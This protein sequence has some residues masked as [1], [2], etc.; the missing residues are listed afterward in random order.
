MVNWS[1]MRWKQFARFDLWTKAEA[2][3]G[4][5]RPVK[6][7]R[8]LCFCLR[9][10]R[11]TVSSNIAPI[12]VVRG[13]CL[14]ASAIINSIRA[15]WE[16]SVASGTT[17]LIFKNT[18]TDVSTST[19]YTQKNTANVHKN[20]THFR[21]NQCNESAQTFFK[22]RGRSPTQFIAI[23]PLQLISFKMEIQT[24]VCL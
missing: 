23:S 18:N 7:G 20:S 12:T 2:E 16:C 21:R 4:G 6:A 24:T 9:S 10:L 19:V 15:W 8:L 3:R 17:W 13:S 11:I 14:A 5:R 22:K 1:E